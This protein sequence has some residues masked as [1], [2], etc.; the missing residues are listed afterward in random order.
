MKVFWVTNRRYHMILRQTFPVHAIPQNL[1]V[2]ED[3]S[4]VVSP[5]ASPMPTNIITESEVKFTF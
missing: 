5:V 2:Q 4:Q 3:V 1:N